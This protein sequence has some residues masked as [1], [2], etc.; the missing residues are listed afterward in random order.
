MQLN[1][2]LLP[3][4]WPSQIEKGYGFREMAQRY[5]SMS[6]QTLMVRGE[7]LTGCIPAESGGALHLD[8]ILSQA[9]LTAHPCP[10]QYPKG[11]AIIPLPLDIL[12]IDKN[13]WP[14]WAST[15]LKPIDQNEGR[16]YWHKRYPAHRAPLG[17][18]LNANTS[19][20]RWREY[21]MPV[22]TIHSTSLT[23]V[24]IGNLDE[25]KRLLD[26]VTHVGK[27]GSIGYGRIKWTVEPIEL[28]DTLSAI[29]AEKALPIEYAKQ[30]GIE[31]IY[32]PTKAWTPPYWYAPN[33]TDCV[34]VP[35]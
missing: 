1:Q 17:S 6:K 10:A 29:H 21:R 32:R 24:C 11:A 19:A 25:V 31:G 14:L 4:V 22:K 18:K 35:R 16:E 12:W 23:A 30:Q 33:W 20:G 8:A 15:D 9:V 2:N 27:K 3:K 26:H 13:G 7:L 34:E 5:Q 28:I